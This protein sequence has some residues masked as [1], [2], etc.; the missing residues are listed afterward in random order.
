MTKAP[1]RRAVRR[2]GLLALLCALLACAAAG[3]GNLIPG[4]G[5]VTTYTSQA[6][7][8]SNNDVRVWPPEPT[9]GESPDQIIDG[10]MLSSASGVADVDIA[11]DY[12]TGSART[13]WSGNGEIFVYTTVLGIEPIGAD[14][15]QL[16]LDIV[17]TVSSSGEYTP[18]PAAPDPQS[19]DFKLV[20]TADGY[21][22]DQLPDGFGIAM[23]PE[24]FRSGYSSYSVFYD[25]QLTTTQH[26]MIP[27]QYYV[28]SG[29]SDQAVA[30]QLADNLVAGPPG[31]ISA[32]AVVA[33]GGQSESQPQ[34]LIDQN[35]VAQVTLGAA[36]DCTQGAC[37]QL[38]DELRASFIGI[39]SVT[40]VQLRSKQN[41]LLATAEPTTRIESEYGITLPGPAGR[42]IANPVVYYLDP[43]GRVERTSPQ[44]GAASPASAVVQVAPTGVKLGELAVGTAAAGPVQIA[45]V[46][47]AQTELYVAQVGSAAP[48]APAFTATDISSLTWDDF[49]DLWFI[50]TNGGAQTVYRLAAQQTQPQP[51]TVD[52][53]LSGPIQQIA[54]APDGRRIAVL[55]G[56]GS[57]DSATEL[58]LGVAEG[59]TFAGGVAWS[60]DLADALEQLVTG[61]N[62]IADV[63]WT[64]SRS[65]AVLGTQT[66][67][68]S[69]TIYQYF[70]DGSP[71]VDANLNAETIT[72]P[73]GTNA[74]SWTDGS[75]NLLLAQ[76]SSC[77]DGQ[78]GEGASPGSSGGNGQ[79]G[80]T[81]QQ[82]IE[83]YE[84]TGG[85][86]TEL[87]PGTWPAIS[88]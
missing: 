88:S 10:F 78:P 23:A 15:Y 32:V 50:A 77:T 59:E 51:V 27:V 8:N 48:T 64:D 29:D 49:G 83:L 54:V 58:S 22:I 67:S 43:S 39:G 81:Q 72:P 47:T 65:L 68:S 19:F 60:L 18:A 69:P 9:K 37:V 62:S 82:F 44:S 5:P 38:A 33:A 70:S 2:R 3:C 1:T 20:Q 21:R 63:T 34:V 26:S 11:E 7:A 46:N 35:G 74:I 56:T 73:G 52:S 79:P 61:W 53:A 71:I 84:P 14:E 28:P 87:V 36:A 85:T 25:S 57:A 17:A 76:C 12:L 4:A 13:S 42:A 16:S 30:G 41:T 80:S 55:T 31:W 86:W 45:A 75:A 40:G 24:Q 66:A 6:S